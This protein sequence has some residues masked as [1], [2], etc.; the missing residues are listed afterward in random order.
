[1]NKDPEKPE[2]TTSKRPCPA[3]V[4]LV[5]LAAIFLLMLSVTLFLPGGPDRLSDWI[6]AGLFLFVISFA[7]ATVLL[8]LWQILRWLSCWRNCPIDLFARALQAAAEHENRYLEQTTPSRLAVAPPG[9]HSS[10]AGRAGRRLFS[11]HLVASSILSSRTSG[12][13][14]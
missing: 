7:A 8:G 12:S 3:I 5:L 2:R 6:P 13:S 4:W 11:L 14:R 10:P 1:M 9:S